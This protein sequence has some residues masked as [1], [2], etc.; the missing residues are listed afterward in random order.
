MVICERIPVVSLCFILTLLSCAPGEKQPEF[1]EANTNYDDLIVLFKEF[2][3]LQE[4]PLNNGI[5][6][7]RPEAVVNQ[8]EMLIDY[9]RQLAAFDI[10]GWPVSEKVNYHLVRAEMNGM[11]FNHRVLRPWSR[12]PN[13]YLNSIP[14]PEDP[15]VA[16]LHET[17]LEYIARGLSTVPT[18]LEQ[19]MENMKDLSRVSGDFA[20]FAIHNLE[21]NNR[22]KWL[23]QIGRQHPG[24]DTLIQAANE[25]VDQYLGWLKD[26]RHLMTEPPGVG[27]D[28]YNWA[29][30]N[31][32][33]FP[34]TW[35]EC[36]R[37]VE[38]EDNRVITFRELE[39]NRNRHLSPLVPDTSQEQYIERYSQAI[40]HVMNFIREKEI[41]TIP[42]YLVPDAYIREEKS[43][44][45]YGLGKP[46]P[47]KHD[48]FFNFSL[49]EP[50]MLETH[51]MV[52]HHFDLL[53]AWQDDRPIRGDREHEGP[54][55]VS[56]ARLE[57]FA[58][59][60]EELMMH[61]G[62]LDERS[63]RGREIAYDQAAFRTVRAM[64]DLRMHNREWSLD[65]AMEYC[66]KNA[67]N[68]QLLDGSPHLWHEMH[69]TL[70]MVGW[71]MQ[72]VV[73]KVQFMKL[74]RDRAQQLGD[75][76][77]L[78]EFMDEYFAAGVIPTALIRWEMTG[79]TDE[80]EK[81]LED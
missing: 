53:K 71:H 67:P 34:Y 70:N 45:P 12:N 50:V 49:R 68:G 80:M 48:Y 57:G 40:D 72:M 3:E 1:N 52:G 15:L 33:L 47:E 30:K 55:H 64:S 42:D 19:A 5:P 39:K 69:S 44:G 43:R 61:A 77:V 73:G 54:Y 10:S 4:I 27:K 75:D 18:L 81:L 35:E 29:L 26:N 21:H 13:F 36:L 7:Y 46:W 20:S 74:F 37:I 25:A 16:P 28:N 23:D 66:V 76:F 62:Y 58:F 9:Q 79:L 60:L 24:L 41:F 17:E 6:E 31:V 56:V 38:L 51:E 14:L 8:W 32:Y 63:P 78:K 65:D 11:E 59:A 22:F 2:R